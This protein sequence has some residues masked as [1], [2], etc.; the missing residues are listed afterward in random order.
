M[1]Q[2]TCGPQD[3]FSSMLAPLVLASG[4]S[5]GVSV[6]SVGGCRFDVVGGSSALC[7]VYFVASVRTGCQ[8][9][10]HSTVDPK[11]RLPPSP[12]NGEP[13]AA[14]VSIFQHGIPVHIRI[15]ESV[16]KA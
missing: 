13:V 8:V 16:M 15:Q 14:K 2:M 4:V 11:D 5:N 12:P 3:S 7:C 10:R 1:K 9:G 6:S